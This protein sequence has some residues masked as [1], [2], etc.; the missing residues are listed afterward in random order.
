MVLTHLTNK[1]DPMGIGA[2]MA[3]DTKSKQSKNMFTARLVSKKTGSMFAWLHITD[4]MAR[5]VFGVMKPTEVT[6]EQA[7]AV[8][9]TI[10]NSD[11]VE[12]KITDLTA[13][14]E[15]VAAEDF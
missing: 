9:P 3:F 4:D 1:Q 2:Y 8:L 6:A 10:F 15:P 13:D 11:T 14:L 7:E 12:V 5:R